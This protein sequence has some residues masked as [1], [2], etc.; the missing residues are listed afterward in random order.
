M[1]AI[2]TDITIGNCRLIL[3]DAMALMPGLEGVDH[4]ISDPPYEQSLHDAKNSATRALRTDGGAELSGLDFAGIDE[5]RADFTDRAAQICRGWFIVFCTPEGCGRWADVINPSPMK[6][7]RAC[8]WVKP[9]STPQLNGQ[10]PAAGAECFVTAWAGRG[11]AKWNAGG[12]RGVYTHLTNPPDRH[13]GHPTEKP[14]RLMRDLLLDFT[15]PGQTVLD[16]FMGSGTTLVAAALT[17]R[18]AIGI[19]LNPAY[20]DIARHRV[21]KAVAQAHALGVQA[22]AQVQEAFL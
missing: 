4:L 9:D 15:Q 1:T 14:W 5:I 6:Y 21:R 19:E 7:K 12:K 17:G 18:R 16:P 10:G 22:S 3:G 2:G 8:I 11:Y 13:G 20:F